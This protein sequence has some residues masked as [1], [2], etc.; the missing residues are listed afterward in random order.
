MTLS[1]TQV[2]RIATIYSAAAYSLVVWDWLVCL[3]AEFRAIWRTKWDL[4]KV[5]YLIAR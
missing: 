2:M 5:L 3:D 4:L 1:Y